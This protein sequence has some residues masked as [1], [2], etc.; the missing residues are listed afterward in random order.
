MSDAA[1][2]AAVGTDSEEGPQQQSSSGGHHH[3][4]HLREVGSGGSATMPR[5]KGI[6]G[7]TPNHLTLSTT[8]TL[9][10]GSTGSAAKLIQSSATPGRNI[11]PPPQPVPEPSE[12]MKEKD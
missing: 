3:H 4:Q 6:L 2:N 12:L 7:N 8:S 11:P 10:A 9:S 5:A 1:N